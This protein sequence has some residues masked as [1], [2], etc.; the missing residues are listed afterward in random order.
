MNEKAW[1]VS[2]YKFS[3]TGGA[4]IVKNFERIRD[5]TLV[6]LSFR[7]SFFLSFL[8]FFLSFFLS[9]RFWSAFPKVTIAV[10]A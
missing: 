7:P 3:F 4:M 9:S 1:S 6:F 5:E 8:P 2:H 10:V